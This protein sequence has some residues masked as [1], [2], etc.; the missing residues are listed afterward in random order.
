[1]RCLLCAA[2]LAA[3]VFADEIPRVIKVSDERELDA[4]LEAFRKLRA[5]QDWREFTIELVGEEIQLSKTIVLN[6]LLFGDGLTI[7]SAGPQ[8]VTLT[9]NQPLPLSSSASG[10]AR[11][12]YPDELLETLGR[13]R[14]VAVNGALTAAARFPNAGYLRIEFAL[15]DRRSGFVT[16]QGDLPTGLELSEFPTDLV[17]LHDW[18]T[19]RLP[20][21]SHDPETRTVKTLGPIGCSAAH[22]KIDHFEKQ[23]RYFLVGHPAFAD[24]PGEWYFDDAAGQVVLKYDGDKAPNL[25]VPTLEQLFVVTGDSPMLQANLQLENIVFE[26]SRFVMP[27]GG[28]AGAQATMHEPRDSDGSRTT[29]HRPLVSAAVHIEQVVGVQVVDC[30]FQNLG[31][32]GLWLGSR[33]E[34]SDVVNCTFRNIGG[35]ALNLGED[36]GRLVDRKS[37]ITVAPDEVPAENRVRGC[38]ISRCGQVLAGAVGIWASFQRGLRIEDCTIT[39]CP[40]TGISLGWQWNASPLPVGGN[41]V[42]G[43]KIQRVM[44]V[45]SD[46]GGVYTLGRQPESVIADNA[47]SDV[48]LNAGRAES[49][50]IFCDQ[51]TTGF[52]ITGNRFERIDRSPVRFHQAGEN[53]VEK[54]EWALA[55]PKT[56][57]VRFNNTPEKNITIRNNISLKP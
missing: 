30:R 45:L 15:S 50:G 5:E 33:I 1:M 25:A 10:V 35:N 23:P 31:N 29:L 18:S 4:A 56:P 47:I 20:I 27:P 3:S 2:C 37:W 57:P 13:P 55:S 11:Y 39:D 24:E 16:Q 8:P 28:Y 46:G 53:V 43:N 7:R 21:S 12:D 38:T 52:L 42:I 26:G 6:D 32:S 49:N 51:G 36:R 17:F 19:S 41:R 44:Q 14:W 9:S 54:N 34:K 48:P 22:Y 40:Y